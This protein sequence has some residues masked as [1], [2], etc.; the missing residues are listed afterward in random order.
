[1]ISAVYN[2][3]T[4]IV[5]PSEFIVALWNFNTE[6][7]RDKI[8]NVKKRIWVTFKEQGSYRLSNEQFAAYLVD[9]LVESFFDDSILKAD[10][11]S[12]TLLN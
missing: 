6:F 3:D 10:C 7:R 11:S 12:S 1:M 4:N 9:E 8:C 2:F 5:K